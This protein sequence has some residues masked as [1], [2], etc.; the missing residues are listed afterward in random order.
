MKTLAQIVILLLLIFA[1]TD[2]KKKETATETVPESNLQEAV[3]ATWTNLTLN[4]TMPLA[5][6][7]SSITV[8]EGKWEEVLGIK[9][10]VTTINEDGT[11]S[12]NYYTLEDELMMTSN[13]SWSVNNDS[14]TMIQNGVP[15]TYHL[16]IQDSIGTFTGYL[17]WDQ[18]GKSDDLYIGT[19][20]KN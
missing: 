19:Q 15:T 20:K 9:P 17:D 18:D 4:V 6:G 5:V 10:I 8:E 2:T 3:V 13:G 1:C 12:S 7:D 11:F 16:S 14:L